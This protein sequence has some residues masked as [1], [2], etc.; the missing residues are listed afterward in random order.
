MLIATK[1]TSTKLAAS[2]SQNCESSID[3]E[4][5]ESLVVSLKD[6]A[7]KKNLDLEFQHS[8]IQTGI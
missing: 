5:S 1:T 7:S 6:D 4:I 2:E 3:I 8:S